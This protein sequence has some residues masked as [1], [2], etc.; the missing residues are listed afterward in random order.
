MQAQRHNCDMG[1][2]SL[3]EQLRIEIQRCGK[4]RYRLSQET[5]VSQSVLSRFIAGK[6]ELTI[7]NAEKV[8]KAIGTEMILK[9]K[10]GK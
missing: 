6:S 2:K 7:A 3:S 8:C 10:K 4:T 5:G 9:T 1:K